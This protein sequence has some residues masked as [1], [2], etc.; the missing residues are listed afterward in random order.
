MIKRVVIAGC[1][2]YGNY[3]E[4]IAFYCCNRFINMVK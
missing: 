1:R 3:N 4:A 2:D